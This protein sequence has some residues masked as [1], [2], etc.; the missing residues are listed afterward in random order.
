MTRWQKERLA[1]Q[2][3]FFGA[4]KTKFISVYARK[5]RIL[6]KVKV[7]QSAASLAERRGQVDLNQ[8]RALQDLYNAQYLRGA[9]NTSAGFSSMAQTK[10]DISNRLNSIGALSACGAFGAFGG[11]GGVVGIGGFGASSQ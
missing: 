6:C 2:L 11:V 9:Q 8:Q 1:E 7:K 10:M 4:K 5:P 3:K